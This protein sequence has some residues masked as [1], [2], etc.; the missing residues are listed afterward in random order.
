MEIVF[1][2]LA[3]WG[4]IMLIWTLVGAVLL[5]LRRRGDLRL[6]VLLRGNGDPNCLERWLRGLVWV[7]ESGLIWWDIVIL[8][9]GLGEESRGI[10]QRAADQY[11]DVLVETVDE[12]KDW[13][14]E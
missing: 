2:M 13:M 11:A 10:A 9:D 5:P 6:T 12:I 3:A 4:L 14:D 1:G 8:S 7:R